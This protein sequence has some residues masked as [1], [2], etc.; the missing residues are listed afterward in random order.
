MITVQNDNRYPLDGIRVDWETAIKE[1]EDVLGKGSSK[2]D[3]LQLLSMIMEIKKLNKIDDT[4]GYFKFLLDH[5]KEY[6][7]IHNL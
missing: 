6:E 2:I 7:I 5:K 4:E 1:V 3:D